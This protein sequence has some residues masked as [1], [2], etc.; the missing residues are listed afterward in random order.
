MKDIEKIEIKIYNMKNRMELYIV[1]STLKVYKKDEEK[2]ISLE[3]IEKL[4]S[5]I[6]TWEHE[7]EDRTIVDGGGYQVLITTST[8]VDEYTGVGAYPTS[9]RQF[10]D[11][12]GDIYDR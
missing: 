8:G 2:D 11:I 7:Y 5:I 10:Q 1:P 12:V 4:L 6:C 9:F 3:Q